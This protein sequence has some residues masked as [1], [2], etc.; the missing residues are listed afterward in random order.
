[1]FSLFLVCNKDD[2]LKL[3]RCSRANLD[4]G[5]GW[6]ASQIKEI[7][8]VSGKEVI[9]STVRTENREQVLRFEIPFHRA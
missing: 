9:T 6:I 8:L 3:S 5:K 1:M 2:C 4:S 7:L